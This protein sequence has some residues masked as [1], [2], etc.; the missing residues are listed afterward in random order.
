MPS[1]LGWSLVPSPLLVACLFVLGTD[2][3]GTISVV[4]CRLDQKKSSASPF[5]LIFFLPHGYGSLRAILD[6]MGSCTP[7]AD[8]CR[9]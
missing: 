8:S 7:R 9:V 2:H 4:S 6:P 3:T 1:Y 5:V